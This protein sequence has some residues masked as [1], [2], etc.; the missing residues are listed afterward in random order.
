MVTDIDIKPHNYDPLSY[1]DLDKVTAEKVVCTI[2]Y[3]QQASLAIKLSD[4][5]EASKLIRL[6]KECY[7]GIDDPL[8]LSSKDFREM[9]Q[10]LDKLDKHLRRLKTLDKILDTVIRVSMYALPIEL[11]LLILCHIIRH[12]HG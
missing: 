3:A 1:I 11:V 6:A 8:L 10:L 4:Y 9:G 7:E 12:L 2:K 5:D